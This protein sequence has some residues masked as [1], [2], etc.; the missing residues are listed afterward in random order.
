MHLMSNISGTSKELRAFV[1]KNF[2]LLQIITGLMSRPSLPKIFVVN[3]V[4]IANNFTIDA[5]DLELGEIRSLAKIF[6]DFLDPMMSSDA[7][8]LVVVDI[9]KGLS[10][11]SE[12]TDPQ[13]L[14][15]IS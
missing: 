6:G 9:L 10:R 8:E 12:V 14:K 3:Y 7:D 5:K 13:V 15:I 2:D 1:R 11:L 4:W